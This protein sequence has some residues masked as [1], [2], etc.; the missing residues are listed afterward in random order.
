MTVLNAQSDSILVVEDG[1]SNP[2]ADD[3][4]TQVMPSI[5][6]SNAASIELFGDVAGGLTGPDPI[7][8]YNERLL[9]VPQL[10]EL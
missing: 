3:G 7:R 10:V 9:I 5:L 8:G 1:S 4:Q 6:F 2:S